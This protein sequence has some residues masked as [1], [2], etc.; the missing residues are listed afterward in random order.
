MAASI[1]NHVSLCC[2]RYFRALLLKGQCNFNPKIRKITGH[3]RDVFTSYWVPSSICKRCYSCVASDGEGA[4][5]PAPPKTRSGDGGGR[6][7]RQ[8]RAA[9]SGD[10]GAEKRKL[11]MA[12]KEARKQYVLQNQRLKQA[13]VCS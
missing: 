2:G 5:R 10:H 7:P 3:S 13:K 4:G 11:L 12:M 1:N 6:S 9:G 8:N